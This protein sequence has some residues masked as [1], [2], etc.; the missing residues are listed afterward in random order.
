MQALLWN[1]WCGRIGMQGVVWRRPV[2]V[3]PLEG[4][5]KAGVWWWWESQA[6]YGI[7]MQGVVWRRPETVETL[8]GGAIR[9]LAVAGMA[10]HVRHY[11]AGGGVVPARERGNL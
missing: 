6:T 10:S 7:T 9:S 2:A 4:G 8:E 5:T 11:C 1:G 3:E